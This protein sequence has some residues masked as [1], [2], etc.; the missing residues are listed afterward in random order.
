MLA[1]IFIF[2]ISVDK[3]IQ[4]H[5]LVGG[6]TSTKKSGILPVCLNEILL[7]SEIFKNILNLSRIDIK[8]LLKIPKLCSTKRLYLR[9]PFQKSGYKM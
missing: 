2:L 4:Y 9:K 5:N 7:Y 1:S 3:T 8:K 6:Q